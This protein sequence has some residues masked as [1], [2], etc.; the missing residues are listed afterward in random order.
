MYDKQANYK[1]NHMATVFFIIILL[2]RRLEHWT[3]MQHQ[4]LKN[5]QMSEILINEPVFD[6]TAAG[7]T[8]ELQWV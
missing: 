2:G 1:I 3:T 8:A 7:I 4:V 5:V 6:A